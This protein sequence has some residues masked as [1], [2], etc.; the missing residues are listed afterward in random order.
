MKKN[1]TANHMQ[2]D[3]FFLLLEQEHRDDDISKIFLSTRFF[4]D[5]VV[6]Y[7]RQQRKIKCLFHIENLLITIKTEKKLLD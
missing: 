4:Y 3:C 2:N 5:V 1:N 7:V 6:K